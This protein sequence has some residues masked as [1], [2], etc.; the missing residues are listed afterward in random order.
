MVRIINLLIIKL[1]L[2]SLITICITKILRRDQEMLIYKTE[3]RQMVRKMQIW[4]NVKEEITQ[5]LA[6]LRQPLLE[7][8]PFHLQIIWFNVTIRNLKF[9]EWVHI[10]RQSQIKSRV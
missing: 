2:K 9:L 1:A 6:T 3:D 10:H 7:I 4:A 5:S 8:R